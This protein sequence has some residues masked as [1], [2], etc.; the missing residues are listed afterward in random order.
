MW[1]SANSMPQFISFD[2]SFWKS[3]IVRLSDHLKNQCCVDISYESAIVMRFFIILIQKMFNHLH[4]KRQSRKVC[5]L[6]LQHY[7]YILIVQQ[8]LF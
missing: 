8:F 6:L 4:N 3:F 2:I 5:L 7:F 1:L